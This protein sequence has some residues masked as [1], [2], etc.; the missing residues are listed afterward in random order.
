VHELPGE[1]H[2]AR[3]NRHPAPGITRPSP[4]NLDLEI[5]R[6]AADQRKGV[7]AVTG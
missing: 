4:S 6:N 3:G 5:G 7:E 2:L 1:I